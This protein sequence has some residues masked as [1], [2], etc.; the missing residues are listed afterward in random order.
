MYI[1]LY[2]KLNFHGDFFFSFKS[3]FLRD[4]ILFALDMFSFSKC[5]DVEF[6]QQVI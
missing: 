3:I 2:F 6:V 1:F 5:D 4:F